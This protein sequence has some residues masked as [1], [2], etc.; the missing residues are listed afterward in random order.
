MGLFNPIHGG[1]SL[2]DV[3]LEQPFEY[4]YKKES[5]DNIQIENSCKHSDIGHY[6]YTVKDVYGLG[7]DFWEHCTIEIID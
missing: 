7:N 6:G 2:L 5:I 4:Q 3:E 1:G